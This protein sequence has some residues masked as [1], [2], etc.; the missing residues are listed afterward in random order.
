MEFVVCISKTRRQHVSIWVIVDKM[1]KYAH[2]IPVSSINNALNYAKLYISVRGAQFTSHIWRS[3]M[4]S[5]G[6][7]VNLSTA[8]HFQIDGKAEHT[9]HT[10]EDMI[11]ACVIDFKGS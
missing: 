11:R 7:H 2:F 9:I 6:T 1:N 4:K 5:L 8:F 10:L 3:F